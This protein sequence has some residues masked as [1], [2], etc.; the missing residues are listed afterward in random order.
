MLGQVLVEVGV[1]RQAVAT[2]CNRLLSFGVSL[3]KIGCVADHCFD[4]FR[5]D[6]ENTGIGLQLD[7]PCV[8]G[9][10][11]NN[12]PPSRGP[13]SLFFSGFDI[14]RAFPIY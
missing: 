10:P 11:G 12:L 4:H 8:S 7:W 1:E 14:S 3:A 13:N 2:V 6:G 5:I 9:V